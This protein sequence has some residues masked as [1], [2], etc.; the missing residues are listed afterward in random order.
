MRQTGTLNI[1][2][3]II[4]FQRFQHGN[5]AKRCNSREFRTSSGWLLHIIVSIIE[6]AGE[7]SGVESSSEPLMYAGVSVID[8]SWE[9]F[10]S[11]SVRSTDWLSVKFSFI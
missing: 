7:S 10:E 5:L 4:L 2:V 8:G 3:F 6:I 9:I 1:Q 11:S